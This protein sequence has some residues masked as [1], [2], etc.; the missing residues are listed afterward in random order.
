MWAREI[1][2]TV[3]SRCATTYRED[4]RTRQQH[5]DRLPVPTGR[6]G[7]PAAG[8]H[9]WTAAAGVDAG[10]GLRPTQLTESHVK[11]SCRSTPR[12][13]VDHATRKGTTVNLPTEV[14][15]L[16]DRVVLCWLAT[17][18][19][20]GVPNVSPKEAFVLRPPA[21]ALIA[22]IASPKTVRN[23]TTNPAVC[24]ALVDVFDQRGYQL[25]GHAGLVKPAD[26]KFTIYVAL[27]ED[28]IG[29][30]Y[31]IRQVVDVTVDR[32][33]KIIAPSYWL[34][35]ELPPRERRQRTTQRYL[36]PGE[37]TPSDR[38]PAES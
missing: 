4:R 36:P 13:D 20:S 30:G 25:H 19:L 6:V 10:E 23:I 17:A 14:F 1:E 7:I 15:E 27:I 18:D 28:R 5:G 3:A 33:E 37:Q 9:D 8:P 38:R 11:L 35:P 34:D 16:A 29:P 21:T 31:P 2:T 32:V 26:A 22:D 12:S 24:L